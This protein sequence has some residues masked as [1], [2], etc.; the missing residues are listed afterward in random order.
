MHVLMIVSNDVIHDSRVIKEARAL[1]SGGHEVTFVGWDRSG[2][3]PTRETW[4]GLDILR[5]RIGGSRPRL[6]AADL[7]RTRL[8]WRRAFRIAREVSFD[9][10]HCHDLDTL[11]VGVRLKRD[12]G[13]ILVYDAHEV[14]GYMIEEDVPRL[15]VDYA[16]RME[17]RL[18]P[19]A[20]YVIAVNDAVK[21]YIDNASGKESVLVRNT[22]ELVLD[23]YRGP[24][25]GPFKVVYIGTLHK[26][27][28]ILPAIEVVGEIPDV[29]LL[30]GG[31]KALTRVVA[32]MCAH[33][34]NTRFVGPVSSDRVLPMTM[35]AHAVLTMYD[36]IP[37]INQVGVPN[38]IYEAM[39]AGRPS[40]VTK[41]LGM[42]E[43]VEREHCGVAV[44]YTKEGFREAVL[45][46][47]DDPA[48]AEQLGR[49]GLQ[50]ARREYQW[51]TD[52]SRLLALYETIARRQ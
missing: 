24:P 51:A 48:L 16:F 15:V 9:V 25:V 26:S 21:R 3:M 19:H 44:P 38:K 12:L 18:A 37:R 49:N 31:S 41:G 40:I 14:F 10:V 8:W 30:I 27:R 42:A 6:F 45:R 34:P 4:E 13:K 1:R 36:P 33:H 50:A 2:R 46:L 20:D 52:R 17:R 23:A 7:L 39:A 29:I 22:Q 5:V 28:F 43:T 47:R 32:S 11:P 35:D